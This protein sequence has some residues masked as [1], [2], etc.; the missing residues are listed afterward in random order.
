MLNASG[1]LDCSIHVQVVFQM[2]QPLLY[3]YFMFFISVLYKG[4]HVHAPTK[5][6]SP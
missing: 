3:P 5:D 1:Y 4:P 2:V 6:C